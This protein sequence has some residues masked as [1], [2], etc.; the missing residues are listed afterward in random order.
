[1]VFVS[2]CTGFNY[3]THEIS[4]DLVEQTNQTFINIESALHK[5]GATF[6]DVVRVTYILKDTADWDKCWPII[7]SYFGDVKP[8][9]TVFCAKLASEQL[10]IEIEVTAILNA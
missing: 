2:G 1:M 10:K 8:A 6:A 9:C 5:A 7:K 4:D 3:L